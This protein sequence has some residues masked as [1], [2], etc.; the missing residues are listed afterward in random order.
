MLYHIN[1][2]FHFWQPPCRHSHHAPEK[3]EWRSPSLQCIP[4]CKHTYIKTYVCMHL[5]IYLPYYLFVTVC[6]YAVYCIRSCIVCIKITVSVS[7]H[8]YNHT[9]LDFLTYSYIH[10]YV[11]S[12]DSSGYDGGGPKQPQ[13]LGPGPGRSPGGGTSP[14][15]GTR[16]SRAPVAEAL[17]VL[18][19]VIPLGLY[20]KCHVY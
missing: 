14:A 11:L 9:F 20:Q 4:V 19:T 18:R 10:T 1:H 17:G 2:V 7:V 12:M 3:T 5:S 16:L 6:T 13:G 15:S 8:I